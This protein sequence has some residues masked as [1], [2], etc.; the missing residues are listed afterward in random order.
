MGKLFV[1]VFALAPAP[2]QIC[3][4][5]KPGLAPL[6]VTKI[7]HL[8]YFLASG[9]FNVANAAQWPLPKFVKLD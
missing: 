1:T 7:L 4:A 3:G 2:R 5:L 8:D 6:Q 9:Q